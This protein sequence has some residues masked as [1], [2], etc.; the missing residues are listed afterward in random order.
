[1]T[2]D[3]FFTFKFKFEESWS[4]RFGI[5]LYLISFGNA[6]SGG[7]GQTGND[8]NN[9]TGF[10]SPLSPSLSPNDKRIL[11]ELQTAKK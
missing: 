9:S 10:P 6:V 7:N 1:M 3:T 2:H 8:S 11:M 4:I 5:F